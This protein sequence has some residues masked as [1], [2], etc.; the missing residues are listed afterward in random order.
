[1]AKLRTRAANSV[2]LKEFNLLHDNLVLRGTHT[3][4]IVFPD[5]DHFTVTASKYAP[6]LAD[7]II[8][9]LGGTNL[10]GSLKD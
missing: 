1:M 2:G 9:F 5:A 3:K 6:R 7:E 4:L 8:R 10:S